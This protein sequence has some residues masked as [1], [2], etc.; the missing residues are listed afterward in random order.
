MYFALTQRNEAEADGTLAG[1]VFSLFLP[2]GGATYLWDDENGRVGGEMPDAVE[3]AQSERSEGTGPTVHVGGRH[4]GG[5]WSAWAEVQVGVVGR[6]TAPRERGTPS[7]PEP[8]NTLPHTA[9]EAL[10]M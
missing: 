9:K 3:R 1:E 7:F 4:R 5:R 2:H 8:V 6:I 10:R